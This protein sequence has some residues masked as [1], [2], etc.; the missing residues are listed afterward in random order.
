MLYLIRNKIG[1]ERGFLVIQQWGEHTFSDA[2]GRA[3][4]IRS[5]IWGDW[6]D[7]QLLD[8]RM[9]DLHLELKCS[10]YEGPIAQL[11][12]ELA[13]RG[14]LFRPYVWISDDG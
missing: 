2:V 10:F 6:S 1:V 8:L 9:C 12:H 11:Q 4:S 13:A 14:L 3:E 5:R 7:E